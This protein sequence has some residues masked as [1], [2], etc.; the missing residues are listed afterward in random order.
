MPPFHGTAQLA[1]AVIITVVHSTYSL[2]DGD[3]S[4]RSFHCSCV[5]S[6]T[7]DACVAAALG[8]TRRAGPGLLAAAA[9]LAAVDDDRSREQSSP[10][11]SGVNSR[12]RAHGTTRPVRGGG[13]RHQAAAGRCG[14]LSSV[15]TAAS[16]ADRSFTVE[17]KR[18]GERPGCLRCGLWGSSSRGT[19]GRP[20]GSMKMGHF[21]WSRTDGRTDGLARGRRAPGGDGSRAGPPP[22]DPEEGGQGTACGCCAY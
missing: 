9:S 8:G 17:S 4:Q 20:A 18:P 12:Q 1:A 6:S 22:P 3:E 19:G 13:G 11:R 14:E 16:P 2:G 7:A 15:K 21:A 5:S 10:V